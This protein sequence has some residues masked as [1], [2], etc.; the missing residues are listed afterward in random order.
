MTKKEL[1]DKLSKEIT[2]T[3]SFYVYKGTKK[4]I[5][6]DFNIF[7]VF[8]ITFEGIGKL[9]KGAL[10]DLSDEILE[11]VNSTDGVEVTSYTEQLNAGSKEN[12]IIYQLH[13]DI[14]VKLMFDLVNREIMDT[15][16]RVIL[17]KKPV[18]EREFIL[19]N[20]LLADTTFNPYD[21][22]P[23]IKVMSEALT[24]PIYNLNT[25]RPPKWQL[26]YPK[27]IE[28]GIPKLLT[29]LIEFLIPIPQEREYLY[30]WIGHSIVNRHQSY[31]HLRGA[32][33]DGKTIL[34]KVIGAI[35]GYAYL[36]RDGVCSDGFNADIRGKRLVIIDDDSF[37]GTRE[38][39]IFRK[40][41]N[42]NIVTL[43]E[44]HFQ[45]KNSEKQYASYIICSNP[46]D[47]FYSTHDERKMVVLTLNEENA[48][49]AFSTKELNF[50]DSL[51]KV[52]ESEH[53]EKEIEFLARSGHFFLEYHKQDDLPATFNY[54]GGEFWDDVLKSLGAFK[55]LTVETLISGD[56]NEYTYDSISYEFDNIKDSRQKTVKFTNL[57][58]FLSNDFTYKG[59]KLLE[60][61]SKEEKK[62]FPIDKYKSVNLAFSEEEEFNL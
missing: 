26:A 59:D 56:K 51:M 52:D 28:G 18:K 16:P 44:K 13:S 60:S 27:G 58:K 48:N 61:F 22:S 23:V 43:N 7:K 35:T 3:S 62:L 14:N 30:S 17:Y 11:K 4:A 53:S 31:L 34:A 50:L 20:M 19:K 45:T 1:I 46:S 36:A 12:T 25:Y 8:N 9:S 5:K 42:N 47:P 6:Q 54:L 2:K 29:R 24:V 39:N 21:P 41:L 38:G 49:T 57:V 55:K 37:I 33:G 40:S 32:R 10:L 15:D